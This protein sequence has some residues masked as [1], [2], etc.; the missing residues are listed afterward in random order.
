MAKHDREEKVNDIYH[1]PTTFIIYLSF[2]YLS[3]CQLDIRCLQLIFPKKK[4]IQCLKIML[5]KKKCKTRLQ[6]KIFPYYKKGTVNKRM[7]KFTKLSIMAPKTPNLWNVLCVCTRIIKAH[8]RHYLTLSIIFLLPLSASSL[9]FQHL[10]K[11]FQQ[12]TTT[13]N[14]KNPTQLLFYLLI[15]SLFSTVFSFGAVSSVTYS[16]Y[17]NFFNR[18]VKLPEAIKAIATSFFPLFATTTVYFLIFSFISALL[19]LLVLLIFLGARLVDTTNSPHLAVFSVALLMLV[20]VPVLIYLVVK[21]SLAQVIVVVESCWGLEP[22]RR[23]A[24][25]VKGRKRLVLSFWFLQSILVWVCSLLTSTATGNGISWVLVLGL[26]PFLA[27]ILLYN[28]SVNT[29]LY[30]SCK[31]VNVQEEENDKLIG[32]LSGSGGV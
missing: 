24:I 16:I 17:H 14:N 7:K 25:L 13:N 21:W 19:L 26:S 1:S 22:L 8:P 12:Q 31:D 10:L 32:L 28:F 3:G 23:S 5:G 18:P 27:V 9:L 30:I 11:H 2:I 6:L 29:V 15:Y 4:I 20:L